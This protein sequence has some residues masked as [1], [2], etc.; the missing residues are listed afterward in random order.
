VLSTHSVK[1]SPDA[2]GADPS[3]PRS[4]ADPRL[5]E[6]AAAYRQLAEQD[7]A[8]G[9]SCEGWLGHMLDRASPCCSEAAGAASP[10]NVIASNCGLA[11]RCSPPIS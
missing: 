8:A 6:M 2:Y 9:L 7:D 5:A 4:D 11:P 3:D 10:K 1:S